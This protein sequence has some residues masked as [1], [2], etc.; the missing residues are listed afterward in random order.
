MW[1]RLQL[2]LTTFYYEDFLV[3]SQE[4]ISQVLEKSVLS[5][6]TLG[7]GA[8]RRERESACRL[9]GWLARSYW[10]FSFASKLSLVVLL[11]RPFDFGIYYL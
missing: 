10:L 6:S 9:P 4:G 1:K 5:I 2:C 8:M 3:G 11:S 7:F